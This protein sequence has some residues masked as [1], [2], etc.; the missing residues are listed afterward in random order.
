MHERGLWVV[1]LGS[2]SL[3]PSD[4]CHLSLRNAPNQSRSNGR[5]TRRRGCNDYRH[6][7]SVS[8]KVKGGHIIER[9]SIT[10]RHVI[11][12]VR[13]RCPRTGPSRPNGKYRRRT[14]ARS[15]QCGV[16]ELHASHATRSSLTYPLPG[17]RRRGVAG[18]G[19]ADRRD[20]SA[21]GPGRGVGA[22]RR[23]VRYF[24]LFNC[25]G[26]TSDVFIHQKGFILQARSHLCIFRRL[27]AK[28]AIINHHARRPRL[29]SLIKDLLRHLGQSRCTFLHAP[30]GLNAKLQLSRASCL[31][32]STV[33]PCMLS[34]QVFVQNGGSFTRSVASR[35]RLALFSRISFV[36]RTSHRSVLHFSVRVFEVSTARIV[37]ADFLSSRCVVLSTPLRGRQQGVTRSFRALT[38]HLRITI[39]RLPM[40]P[41]LVPFMKF[42]NPFKGRRY[43]IHQGAISILRRTVLGAI[44]KA[45]RSR[46]RRSTPRRARTNR[47]TANFVANSHRPCFRPTVCVGCR[48]GLS[49][50]GCRLFVTR[51]LSHHSLSHL[52]NER[53]TYRRAYSSSRNHDERHRARI[54]HQIRR[55]ARIVL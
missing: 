2:G 27:V 28:V 34:S 51:N 17:Y 32:V 45:R 33:R 22:N 41:F 47:R 40:A 21:S 25:H 37:Y 14:L 31:M 16:R 44:T 15:L 6:Y 9:V 23:R 52:T 43:K 29:I 35:T 30:T 39:T 26:T 54:R 53:V 3:F 4:V 18:P 46:R 7:P 11:R 49:V 8:F 20:S 19:G 10:Y 36:W 13:R 48:R 5:A 12:R 50:F 38:S 24:R 55:S 42:T 1:G